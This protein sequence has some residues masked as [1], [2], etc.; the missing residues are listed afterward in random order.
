MITE[1]KKNTF[2]ERRANLKK[3]Q[4]AK[5]PI[6]DLVGARKEDYSYFLP[7]MEE[8]LLKTVYEV[9]MPRAQR[10]GKNEILVPM[11]LGKQ[12]LDILKSAGRLGLSV[13]EI[14]VNNTSDAISKRTLALFMSWNE[15]FCGTIYPVFEIANI[16]SNEDVFLFVDATDSVGKVF[17]RYQDMPIDILAFAYKKQAAVFS[18]EPL[19]GSSWGENYC[20]DDYFIMSEFANDALARLDISPMEYSRVKNEVVEKYTE[21][22]FF[23]EGADFLFDRWCFAV[24]LVSSE[25]LAYLLREK[26]ILVEYLGVSDI[27]ESRGVEKNLSS[28]AVSITFT[29]DGST[30]EIFEMWDTILETAKGIREY[31]NA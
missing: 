18:K 23:N 13:K 8:A 17:F 20:L 12:I 30:D 10:T 2:S 11:G 14:D 1:E 16:C 26:G 24:P 6:L 19:K 25:N 4:K 21:I 15:E 27:L 28:C 29:L 31:S 3:M 5:D 7:S 9:L 22:T